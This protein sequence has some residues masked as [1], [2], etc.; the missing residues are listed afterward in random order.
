MRFGKASFNGSMFGKLFPVDTWVLAVCLGG[1]ITMSTYQMFLHARYDPDIVWHQNDRDADGSG[2]DKV[3]AA[4][5][6]AYEKQQESNTYRSNV[7]RRFAELRK[8]STINPATGRSSW[9]TNM[10]PSNVSMQH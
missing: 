8:S 5:S 9:S 3:L 6:D 10:W 4:R 1:A 7:F 2:T